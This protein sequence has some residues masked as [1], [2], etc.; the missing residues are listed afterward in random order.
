QDFAHLN[1]NCG[2][3]PSKAQSV[4][5][6]AMHWVTAS[7]GKDLNGR[8]EMEWS[9]VK[10]QHVSKACDALLRSKIPSLKPGGLVVIYKNERLPAKAVLRLAYC[11]ANNISTE[12]HIKFS[13]GETSLT[14]LR[15]LGFH[16]ERLQANHSGATKD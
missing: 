12:A 11:L 6:I 15:L 1:S 4:P 8:T 13:S 7:S 3:I 16:A 10:A 2:R 5:R 9:S 14:R